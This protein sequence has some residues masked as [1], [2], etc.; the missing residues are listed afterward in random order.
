MSVPPMRERDKR[1]ST[2]CKRE[3]GWKPV[4][5]RGRRGAN[6]VT[7]RLDYCLARTVPGALATAR[8]AYA[9]QNQLMG[10]SIR[11]LA[12][13]DEALVAEEAVKAGI[14]LT[15]LAHEASEGDDVALAGHLA[16]LVNLQ[17]RD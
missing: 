5:A 7:Y 13:A 12:E 1:I 16:V 17:T 10:L 11:S 3:G 14:S 2:K 8:A 4:K 9:R 15:T 6:S